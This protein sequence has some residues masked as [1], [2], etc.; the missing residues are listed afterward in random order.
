MNQY[1]NTILMYLMY[2]QINSNFDCFNVK[3]LNYE[4]TEV[5]YGSNSF[6]YFQTVVL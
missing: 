6:Q 2:L 5:F 3:A 1:S 4:L